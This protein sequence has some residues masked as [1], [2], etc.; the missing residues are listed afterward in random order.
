MTLEELG[1]R[2]RTA[3]QGPAGGFEACCTPDVAYEDPIAMIP[4]EGVD[5]LE[6]YAKTMRP[7]S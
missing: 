3:W 7:L 4:L 1:E 2:W 5:A 6:E